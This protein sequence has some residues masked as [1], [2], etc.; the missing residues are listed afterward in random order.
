[1]I[2]ACDAEKQKNCS[3]CLSIEGKKLKSY[4][5]ERYESNKFSSLE[6]MICDFLK[7]TDMTFKQVVRVFRVLLL[8]E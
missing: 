2:L 7:D 8:M 6:E 3:F 5:S 4:K 1:M